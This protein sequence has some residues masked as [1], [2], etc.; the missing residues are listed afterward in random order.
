MYGRIP[1]GYQIILLIHKHLEREFSGLFLLAV[2]LP[3]FT[4]ALCQWNALFPTFSH[5]RDN[6][7]KM[8]GAMVLGDGVMSHISTTD[9]VPSQPLLAQSHG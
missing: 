9:I 5:G 2:T 1:F 7:N 4:L 3:V 8:D 6:L